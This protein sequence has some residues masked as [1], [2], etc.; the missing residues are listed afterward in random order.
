MKHLFAAAVFTTAITG[1]A[2][3]ST[4]TIDFVALAAGINTAY[5]AN[6]ADDYGDAEGQTFSFAGGL[7]VTL[8]STAN[9]YLDDLSGGNPGGLG[10]CSAGI[11][12]TGQCFDASD[13]NVTLGESVTLSFGGATTFAAFPTF[14]DSLQ[15][16]PISSLTLSFGGNNPL[17]YYLSSL[18][19]DVTAVSLP[20][21]V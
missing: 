5:S 14:F 20:A 10:V 21:S 13:D 12:A 8:T 7:D 3:A 11:S 1:A 19:L 17:E 9:A 18:T 2:S 15:A 6:D 16:G 4:V